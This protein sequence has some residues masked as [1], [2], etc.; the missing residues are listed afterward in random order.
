LGVWAFFTLL[1][2]GVLV[3]IARRP[4]TTPERAMREW[5][6]AYIHGCYLVAMIVVLSIRLLRPMKR[7]WPTLALNIA[8]LIN[9][10]VGTALAIY[11]LMRADKKSN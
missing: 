11:G 5:S 1:G 6:Y 7:R 4:S 9:F 2:I 8:L 3:N 10:P